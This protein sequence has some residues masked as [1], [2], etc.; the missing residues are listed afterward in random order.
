MVRVAIPVGVA[1]VVRG[2]GVVGGAVC[3]GV[4]G[5]KWCTFADLFD[6][7]VDYYCQDGYVQKG[8]PV[9][10]VPSSSPPSPPRHMVQIPSFEMWQRLTY[11]MPIQ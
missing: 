11:I 8:V 7:V 5:V 10:C 2:V 6:V 1:V 9:E 3:I 4:G